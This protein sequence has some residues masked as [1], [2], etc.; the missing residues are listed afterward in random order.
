MVQEEIDRFCRGLIGHFMG[1][2]VFR[3]GKTIS[4]IEV[5]AGGILQVNGYDPVFA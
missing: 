5:A 3:R 2:S 4:A 1:M